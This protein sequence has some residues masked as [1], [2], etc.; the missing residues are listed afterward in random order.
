MPQRRL[1][2]GHPGVGPG[3]AG[4][5]AEGLGF[6]R[7]GLQQGEAGGVLPGVV[8]QDQ[9]IGAG[10]GFLAVVEH[11]LHRRRAERVQPGGPQDPGRLPPLRAVARDAGIPTV[12]GFAPL[13]VEGQHA[14]PG[15]VPGGGVGEPS[16]GER[17]QGRVGPGVLEASPG[18]LPG[19][20]CPSGH[21]ADV[22]GL[23]QI[24]GG[25]LIPFGGGDGVARLDGHRHGLVEAERPR[26]GDPEPPEQARPPLVA[27]RQ[28][29]EGDAQEGRRLVEAAGRFG[30]RGGG[31]G[32][33]HAPLGAGEGGAVVVL[34]GDLAGLD[35]RRLG[36]VGQFEHLGGVAV[37][38]HPISGF[39]LFVHGVAHEVMGEPG[40]PRR[41]RL[42]QPGGLGL[43]ERVAGLGLGKVGHRR[44]HV[45]LEGGL[46]GRSG[47]EEPV[48]RIREPGQAAADDLANTLPDAEVDGF[49]EDP[50]SVGP[51]AELAF[52]GE[53]AHNLPDE[54]R[55]A[56]GLRRNGV[57]LFVSHG[58]LVAEDLEEPGDGA[59]R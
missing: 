52:F 28:H 44:H 20:H 3:G 21:G 56:L 8:H 27:R 46:E 1:A 43:V 59:G 24:L 16:L 34:G 58:V 42:Q 40:R 33:I 32:G 50:A 41:R 53:V 11:R 55:V 23:G 14:S 18:Q 49:G 35:R 48:G 13:A 47:G 30:M 36:P 26:Q 12:L 10:Q 37:E 38:P 54:E 45:E 51:P 39:E 6:L 19:R 57:D 31:Q 22:G 15:D 29:V 4:Q 5:P 7:L 25:G 17:H 2:D 9:Q